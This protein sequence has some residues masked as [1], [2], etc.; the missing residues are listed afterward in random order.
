MIIKK[1]IMHILTKKK[2]REF[3]VTKGVYE[4][5]DEYLIDNFIIYVKMAK[6]AREDIEKR[7]SV[8]NIAKPENKPY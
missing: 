3:L 2:L 7:G 8:M 5:V 6:E 1:R 4:E